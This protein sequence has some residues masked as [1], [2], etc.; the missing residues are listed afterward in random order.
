[1]RASDVHVKPIDT[2]SITHAC[3]NHNVVRH[4]HVQLNIRKLNLL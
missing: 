4:L 1:L 3:N 2:L